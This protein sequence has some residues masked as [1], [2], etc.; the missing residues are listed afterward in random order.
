[1]IITIYI[2]WFIY[3]Y[4]HSKPEEFFLY[5]YYRISKYMTCIKKEFI[6]VPNIFILSFTKINIHEI[7]SV[8]SISDIHARNN[9]R[10][11]Q[12]DTKGKLEKPTSR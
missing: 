6:Q 5:Y 1:M 12:L 11:S 7:S 10:G 8:G 2:I 4:E 9:S 3:I